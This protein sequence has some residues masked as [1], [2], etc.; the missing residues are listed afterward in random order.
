LKF[1]VDILALYYTLFNRETLYIDSISHESVRQVLKKNEIKP[2]QKKEWCIPP[3]ENAEFVCS[4]ENVLDN[5]RRER[6][7]GA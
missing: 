5:W 3:K 1:L 7:K 6:Q 4:M 2:W